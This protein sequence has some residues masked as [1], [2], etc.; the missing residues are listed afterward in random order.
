[1]KIGIPH[2]VVDFTGRF[3]SD[4]IEDFAAEYL[5]GRTPNPCII[6]NRKIKW[7]LLLE[8]ALSLGADFLATGHYARVLPPEGEG[9]AGRYRL[10]RA[11]HAAKDQSYALWGL[12][13]DALSKT[14]FPLGD[15]PKDRVRTIAREN[16]LPTA[17][18]EESYEICFV[19]DNDYGRFIAEY[20]PA[21]VAGIG[22]G[23]ILRDGKPVGTHDG[24]YRYTIGQRSGIGA[25]GR[26]MYVTSIDAGKNTLTVGGPE[27]LMATS[28]VADGLNF[29]SVSA[30]EDGAGVDAQIRYRD[31]PGP[32]R[33][34]GA[35]NGRVRVE[36]DT[37][38]RAVTPGQ[39]V[40][41][42]DGDR[43][44]AGGVIAAAA[45]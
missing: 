31:A 43:L 32:A 8:K 16:G 23:D 1:V 42:Y 22:P 14:L 34:F 30:L 20:D 45:E 9:G 39:S 18:K 24:Y 27:E 29:V 17:E 40:V 28:L 13:Q 44:L 11:R 21:R 6:C 41:F 33:I 25:F 15:L 38:R 19:A 12:S 2:Y 7:G 26:R 5:R 10:L 36:F 37:P 35:G 4:V 3:E